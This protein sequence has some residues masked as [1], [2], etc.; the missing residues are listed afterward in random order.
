MILKGNPALIKSKNL[1]CP[2]PYTIR[3][4]WYPTG[5]IKLLEAPKHTA[6]INGLGS[7]W[8]WVDKAIAIGV[9]TIAIALFETNADKINVTKYLWYVIIKTQNFI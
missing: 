9:I 4:V 1:Y 8:R 3:L 2:G 6:T 7:I 5:V